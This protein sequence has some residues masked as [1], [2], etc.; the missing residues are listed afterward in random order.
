MADMSSDMTDGHPQGVAG[1]SVVDD[2][3]DDASVGQLA[4]RLSA[5]IC[6]HP[7]CRHTV[8]I[9]SI[10]QSRDYFHSPKNRKNQEKNIAVYFRVAV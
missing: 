9:R 8:P 2:D 7:R 3:D 1:H 10:C 6:H 5:I 4:T